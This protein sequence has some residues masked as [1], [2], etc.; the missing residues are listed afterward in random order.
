[1]SVSDK[2]SS[3][4][5]ATAKKFLWYRPQRVAGIKMTVGKKERWL[6]EP[7]KKKIQISF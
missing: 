1:M 2:R 3:L 6:A 5:T 4:F 7:T